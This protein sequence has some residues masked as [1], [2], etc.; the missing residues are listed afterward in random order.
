MNYQDF[1]NS[2]HLTQTERIEIERKTLGQRT[3][4][5]WFQERYGR[6][7]AS[8]CSTYLDHKHDTVSLSEWTGNVCLK[9]D[10]KKKTSMFFKATQWGI[11]HEE[12]AKNV[13]KIDR[14]D[15]VMQECGLI[16]SECG[17]LGCSP[18]SII[19]N[20]V[21]N[22]SYLLEIKCPY[23]AKSYPSLRKAA[24]SLPGFYLREMTCGSMHR[25]MALDTSSRI[26]RSYYHQIM[27]S[28]YLTGLKYCDFVVWI[29][30]D[31]IIIRID[32]DPDWAHQNVNVLTSAWDKYIGRRLHYNKVARRNSSLTS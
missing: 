32:W 7:T 18:D 19:R 8:Q 17:R 6:I 3:N 20:T 12:T 31:I 22:E 13:Y 21:T 16:V 10:Q 15:I 25:K 2:L 9:K 27:L 14:R 24:E 28:M 11:K 4:Q 1:L 5:T 26:G 30:K 23:R 29:P